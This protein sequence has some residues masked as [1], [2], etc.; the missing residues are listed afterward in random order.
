M[1]Y[2]D[3]NGDAFIQ[4]LH[5]ITEM[6]HIFQQWGE[7]L[8][9][10]VHKEL[11]HI[12]SHDKIVNRMLKGIAIILFLILAV[13]FTISITSSMVM[14]ENFYAND[15]KNNAKIS[16]KKNFLVLMYQNS[17][18]FLER[19]KEGIHQKAEERQIRID[20][21]NVESMSDAIK[22]IN[23]AVAAK[24]D[25]IIAQGIYDEDYIDAINQA[26]DKGISVQFVYTD[27]RG[28]NRDYFVGYN[29]YD[30]GK[31]AARQTI[32]VL[33]NRP[34]N[35]ALIVQSVTDADKDVTSS[36]TIEGFKS[37][38]DKHPTLNLKDI[39]STSFDLFSG[40]DAAYSILTQYPDLDAIVCTS[41][42]D[43]FGAAQVIID[44]NRVGE[45]KLIGVG[46]SEDI[47]KYIRLEVI[48]ASF[49]MNPEMMSVRALDIMTEEKP[50]SD[51]IEIPFN[52]VTAEN[53]HLFGK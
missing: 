16:Y 45:T 24:V 36:L 35:I 9:G 30:Y 28:T 48:A 53:V 19:F 13:A 2:N 44:L 52:V 21:V 26:I 1:R 20:F 42:K 12:S 47:L 31:K 17:D 38:I 40:E 18:D 27:A 3:A 22:S 49:D 37:V 8:M 51:Y 5:H 32:E 7:N 15:K 43:T 11:L 4:N 14:E 39:A 34:V 33:P 50:T 6:D 41:E 23:T 10:D 25:G 46:L 29:A